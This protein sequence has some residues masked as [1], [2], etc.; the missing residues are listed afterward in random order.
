MRN[1]L[2]A[3]REKGTK[4]H[5]IGARLTRLHREMAAIVAGDSDLRLTPQYLARFTGI[6]IIL[7]Q[8]HAIRAQP[9]GKG[10]A[11]IDDEGDVPIS[12]NR[13]Q[14]CGKARN[15]VVIQPLETQLKG[16]D[17][18][19]VKRGLQAIRKACV[20]RRWRQDV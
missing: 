6:A 8:M 2:G 17:W 7:A 18:P 1:I 10:D 15:R 19:C 5:I 14:G 20:N 13:L 11:V 16:S 12:T 3:G 4:G 9:F